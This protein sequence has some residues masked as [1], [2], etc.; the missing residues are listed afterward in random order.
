MYYVNLNVDEVNLHTIP[1]DRPR[2]DTPASAKQ[3]QFNEGFPGVGQAIVAD[4]DEDGTNLGI[5]ATD[6]P[7]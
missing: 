5:T 3:A 2:H 4:V 7:D 1:E 6:H